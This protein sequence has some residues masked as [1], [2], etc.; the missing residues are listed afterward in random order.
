MKKNATKDSLD[1]KLP[2]ESYLMTKRVHIIGGGWAGLAAAVELCRKGVPVTVYE[3]AKKLG[4]RA[5]SVDT[6]N[7][8]IDNG[9]H[10]MIGA[11]QQMLSLLNKIGAKESQLFHRLPQQLEIFD[12]KTQQSAFSL[13]LP[14]LPAPLHLLIGLL[15]CPSLNFIEKITT[16]FQFNKLLNKKISADLSVD[17]WLAQA[18]LPEKYINYL[19]KPLCLAALT[20]HTHAA[21]AKI[22]QAVLQQTF[23]GSSKN[24]DLLIPKVGLS[25]VF[26]LAAKQYIEQH[27][28]EILTE[29]RVN[30]INFNFNQAVSI[31][32]KDKIINT[33]YIILATA[34]YSIKNLISHSAQ[35]NNICE[36][37]DQLKYEPVIT[38]YLQYPPSIQLP[39]P[40][41]G[42]INANSEWLF[43]RRYCN[44]PGLIAAVISAEG[45]HMAFDKQALSERIEDELSTLFPHW[46]KA[47]S[48]NIIREKRACFHCAVDIDKNRPGTTTAIENLTLCGDYVYFE[49]NNAAG[50]PST[51]EGSVSSGVK[52]AQ[53]FIQEYL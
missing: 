46:P 44:Q 42:V 53:T 7:A 36:Q 35:L 27:G 1:N 6:D 18:K 43:D 5:R 26:P 3:S 21:S 47:T 38:V 33:D 8:I 11:Y 22:F 14:K 40:M 48:I 29:H 12:F 49:E 13:K 4:G 41:L 25:D 17:E 9:Q 32:V 37:I 51:L 16:L 10:L 23:N 39:L 50:L 2:H 19:L 15:R 28:G 31:L 30:K 45:S 52:C 24:T 20:T 34:A